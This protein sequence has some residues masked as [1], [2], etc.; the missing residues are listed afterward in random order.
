MLKAKDWDMLQWITKR[1]AYKSENPA[2]AK[3]LF[4]LADTCEAL[5][6]AAREGRCMP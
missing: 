4:E 3:E 6:N 1:A 5:A 2:V